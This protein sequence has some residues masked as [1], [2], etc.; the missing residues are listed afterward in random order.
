ME[1]KKKTIQFAIPFPPLVVSFFFHMTL[2]YVFTGIFFLFY[3]ISHFFRLIGFSSF[4]TVHVG[5]FYEKEGEPFFVVAVFS[6]GEGWVGYLRQSLFPLFEPLSTSS[7]FCGFLS[8]P[9]SLAW[10]LLYVFFFAKSN[11]LS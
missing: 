9:L 7:S 11:L 5:F 2:S 6:A 4:S 1:E 3:I 10:T 8:T